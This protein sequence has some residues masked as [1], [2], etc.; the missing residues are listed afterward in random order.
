MV[1][2]EEKEMDEPIETTLILCKLLH[3]I[4]QEDMHDIK[5]LWVTEN[6]EK[7]MDEQIIALMPQAE[8]I[9]MFSA[10]INYDVN[11]WDSVVIVVNGGRNREGVSD[12]AQS[13]LTTAAQFGAK[14]LPHIDEDSVLLANV[15]C[16]GFTCIEWFGI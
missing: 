14:Y 16:F 7:P 4:Q 8:F 13:A 9:A 11:V 1:E 2:V 6:A 10:F 5:I 3:A 12:G 15:E